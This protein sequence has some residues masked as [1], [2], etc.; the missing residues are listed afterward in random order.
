LKVEGR[1]D[2]FGIEGERE[3]HDLFTSM[4]EEV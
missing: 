3:H 4:L 2:A 1:R